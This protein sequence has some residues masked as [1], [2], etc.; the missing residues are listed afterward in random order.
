MS[1]K[2]IYYFLS[3]AF[4]L[5]C[6]AAAFLLKKLTAAGAACGVL[7]GVLLLWGFGWT[8]IA[9]MSAFFILGTAATAVGRRKKMAWNIAEREHGRRHAGQVLANG[10]AGGLFAL[11]ALL[12]AKH[13]DICFI[14]AASAFSAATAD[15]LSSE[16]GSIYGRRY[17][18]IISFR[19]DQR[20]LDGVVSIEGTLIGLA[21][22]M[23][24]AIIA[25]SALGWS[26]NLLWIVVAGT[27][28]NLVDSVLGAVLERKGLIGNDL[29]NFLNTLAAALCGGLL[30]IFFDILFH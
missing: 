4:L 18:N 21:G 24:I 10:G 29:V 16:L 3:V 17:Y 5:A 13:A 2:F 15:T 14:M 12:D 30:S 6:G 28:G 19:P 22:S 23:L 7:L 26:W 20:G 11:I 8:G 1:E 25:A 27:I 9:L